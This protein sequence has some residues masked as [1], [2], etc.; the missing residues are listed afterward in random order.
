MRVVGVGEGDWV[1]VNLGFVGYYRMAYDT[2]RLTKAVQTKELSPVDRL[3]IIDNLFSLIMAGK[4]WTGE[5]LRLL[6][7]YKDE[8]SYIVWNL[9]SNSIAKLQVIVAYQDYYENFKRFV[10]YVFSVI[11]IKTMWDPAT[12]ETYFDTLLWSLV[13]NKLRRYLFMDFF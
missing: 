10:L 12:N 5:G 1:K 7:A 8:D 2:E 4:A 3:Q 9:I 13:L 6:K 11:K